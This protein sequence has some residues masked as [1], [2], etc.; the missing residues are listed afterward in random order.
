MTLPWCDF[1]CLEGDLLAR[2]T[3]YHGP[4][5]DFFE[6]DLMEGSA[7]YKE[8][9]WRGMVVDI[10]LQLAATLNFTFTLGLSSDRK[11]GARNQVDLIL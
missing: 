3:L 8:Q 4:A 10:W 5:F 9:P 1:V 11:W 6:G 2:E 7:G